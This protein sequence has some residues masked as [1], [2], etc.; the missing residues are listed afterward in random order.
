M[1]PFLHPWSFKHFSRNMVYSTSRHPHYGWPRANGE[2]ERQNRS[3]LKRLKIAALKKRNLQIELAK[4]ILLY[5]GTPHSSTGVSQAE[6]MLQRRIRDKLPSLAHPSPLYDVVRDTDAENKMR[7]KIFADNR[8]GLAGP[9]RFLAV[10]D[11]LLVQAKKTNKLPPTFDPDPLVVV[12]T[13]HR[14]VTLRRGQQVLRRSTSAVKPVPQTSLL[15]AEP[16]P[17]VLSPASPPTPQEP[18]ESPSLMAPSPISSPFKGF[19]DSHDQTMTPP[20]TGD[21]QPLTTRSGRV[22]NPPKRLDW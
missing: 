18:L 15:F 13:G 22:I 3:I 11:Q 9:K 4:Y 21:S 5:H 2:V 16:V 12:E 14:E 8:K 10:G 6:L 20:E 7:G 1:P 19:P 17:A